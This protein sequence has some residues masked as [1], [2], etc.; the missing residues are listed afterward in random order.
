MVMAVSRK[1]EA[2]GASKPQETVGGGA[3]EEGRA[4][5]VRFALRAP[6]RARGLLARKRF[7]GALALVPCGDVHTVGMR[8]PVDVA[9]I[10]AGGVVLESHRGVPPCRRL[11]N[12]QAAWVL[13]RMSRQDACWPPAGARIGLV[14][15]EA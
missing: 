5:P 4:Y 2:A 7:D 10:D 9:F 14:V 1:A 13:E 15:D 11:R 12:R 6:A 3:V 8:A